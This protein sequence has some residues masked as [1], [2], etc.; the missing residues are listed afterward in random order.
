[1]KRS[2]V[3]AHHYRAF[4]LHIGSELDL[5]EFI[6]GNE[7]AEPDV[8]IERGSV[9]AP[10]DGSA[11]MASLGGAL[12]LVIPDVGRYRIADGSLITVDAAAGVPEQNIRLY[13]LGSAF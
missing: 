3:V 11:G 1:M 4:G 2:Q 13:L 10:S 9:V 7:G 5:P 12:V 8:R 6:E